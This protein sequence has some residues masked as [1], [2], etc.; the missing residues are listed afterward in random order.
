MLRYLEEE[1]IAITAA[2]NRILL[3]LMVTKI[4]EKRCRGLQECVRVSLLSEL[5]A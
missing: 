1:G 5:R 2:P 3:I 4:M